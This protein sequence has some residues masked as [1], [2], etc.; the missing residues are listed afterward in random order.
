MVGRQPQSPLEATH[1]R[2]GC[3]SQLAQELPL[4]HIDPNFFSEAETGVGE[5]G[6]QG[7][8][9][10]A[11]LQHWQQRSPEE[12]HA[13]AEISRAKQAGKDAKAAQARAHYLDNL[14]RKTAKQEEVKKLK[15][16]FRE[17]SKGHT[18][19]KLKVENEKTA[20]REQWT[21]GPHSYCKDRFTDQNRDGLEQQ[22]WLQTMQP[23]RR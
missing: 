8:Y 17:R 9:T 5:M 2:R 4:Q 1:Y 11:T 3:L 14:R 6:M 23:W 10:T 7:Q 12:K 21:H 18:A 19:K 22:R 20:D 15:A 16:S 13:W